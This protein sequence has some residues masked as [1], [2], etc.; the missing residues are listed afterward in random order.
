MLS[1]FIGNFTK[2]GNNM[3]LVID[4]NLK[5][6]DA[7]TKCSELGSQLVEFQD[8]YEYNEVIIRHRQAPCFARYALQIAD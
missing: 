6:D 4:E 3:L 7:K 5:Y 8:E 2:V 1:Y